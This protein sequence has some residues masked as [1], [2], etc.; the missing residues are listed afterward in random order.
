MSRD[1]GEL[2]REFIDGLAADTGRSLGQWMALIDAQTFPHRNDM[3]D[4]LRQ[5]GLTFAKASRLE[6]IHHNGGKPVYGERPAVRLAGDDAVAAPRR[7]VPAPAV[8]APEPMPAAAA[9]AT[10][11]PASVIPTPTGDDAAALAA[12]LA[13]AKGYRPLAELLIRF[14][15]ATVPATRLAIHDTH[16]DLSAPALFGALAVTA[17][18]VRLG[19]DLGAHPFEGDLKRLRLPGTAPT[20]THTIVLNDAR[21][22]DADLAGLIAKAAS[23]T[24]S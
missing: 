18:D 14:V 23:R 2:E 15:Q 8:P 17:R 22:I 20:L 21:R 1:Y 9:A 12:F 10:V 24:N 16:A 13:R 5:Q 11:A 7:P 19:L 3:I 4:W 6:R